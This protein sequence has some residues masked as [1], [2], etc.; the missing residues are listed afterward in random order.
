M[1]LR[2]CDLVH[3]QWPVSVK[4][5]LQKYNY[6]VHFG[7]VHV[8]SPQIDEKN[9]TSYWRTYQRKEETFQDA[10]RRQMKIEQGYLSGGLQA[11]SDL[12][13]REDHRGL[14]KL[15]VLVFVCWL[16]R[17]EKAL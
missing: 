6:S 10:P 15:I 2:F 4:Y 5:H 14:H 11:L 17:K 1:C 9:N 12:L 13:H 8:I 3:S 7:F 16:F